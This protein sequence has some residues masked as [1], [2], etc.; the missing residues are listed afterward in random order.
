[1]APLAAK[2]TSV[3]LPVNASVCVIPVPLALMEGAGDHCCEYMTGGRT[4]GLGRTGRNFAAG[5]SGG[6]SYVFD[7]DQLF[8]TF[9]NLEM[10]DL[11]PVTEPEDAALLKSLIEKHHKYTGSLKAKNILDTWQDSIDRFVKVFPIDYKFA[12]ERI[13][14]AELRNSDSMHV[15]EEVLRG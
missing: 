6:I 13:R 14:Q 12:L 2:C 9:C 3:V 1:M 10:V 8:D 5:M 7:V 11:M 4:V 15:T